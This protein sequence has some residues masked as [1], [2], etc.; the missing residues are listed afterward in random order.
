MASQHHMTLRRRIRDDSTHNRDSAVCLGDMM[1][2]LSQATAPTMQDFLA[3]EPVVHASS[4]MPTGYDFVSKGNPYITRNCRR[5]TQ[6]AHQVVYAVVNDEK[7]Q[8]GIRV[9]WSVHAAVLQD[10][11][12]TRL[13]RQQKVRKYDESL[14]KRFREASE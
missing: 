11:R 7:K 9:P 4:P 2:Q 10:E 8:I 5:Q 13:E 14:E 1:P 12:A 6:L 3:I